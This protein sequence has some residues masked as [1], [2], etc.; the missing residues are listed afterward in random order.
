MLAQS[1]FAAT[2]LALASFT[3]AAPPACLLGAI[4]TYPD[5]SDVK[6]VCTAKDVT[7][8]VIKY[9]SGDST[10]PALSAFADICNAAGVKVCKYCRFFA[11]HLS[12]EDTTRTWDDMRA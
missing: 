10:K 6:S 12:L 4:N 1:L 7:S 11:V 9:C 3:V 8:T 2:F 5:P